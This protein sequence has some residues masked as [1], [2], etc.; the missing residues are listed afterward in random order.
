MIK[1]RNIVIK[2]SFIT[3]VSE[4]YEFQY[5][6]GNAAVSFTLIGLCVSLPLRV[7]RCQFAFDSDI[8][9]PLTVLCIRL[10]LTRLR[11]SMLLT[12]QRAF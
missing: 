12:V 5:N 1:N 11:V 3:T 9:R 10:P 2:V 8:S 7:L 4:S 6:S